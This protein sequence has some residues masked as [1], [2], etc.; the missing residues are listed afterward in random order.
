MKPKYAPLKKYYEKLKS[1]DGQ[2]KQTVHS[3]NMKSDVEQSSEFNKPK[4]EM[5]SNFELS[6]QM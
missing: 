2:E 6:N 5:Q 4:N 3:Q 1:Y